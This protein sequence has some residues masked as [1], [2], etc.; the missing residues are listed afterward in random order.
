M[1]RKILCTTLAAL[2]I[3]T[4]GASLIAPVQAA[5]QDD[6]LGRMLT[7]FTTFAQARIKTLDRSQNMARSKMV[8]IKE[9]PSYRGTYHT[10]DHESL[11]CKV[12]K[13]R[14]ETIPFVGVMKFNVHIW[15]AKG[16]T[17]E[18]VKNGSFAPVKIQPNRQIYSF[19]G[20]A[21]K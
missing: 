1:R 10:F 15:Q 7:H 4:L 18:A 12:R 2:I 14:S 17:I 13:S 19:K 21:W 6:E 20:G 8:V 11:T 5:A 3:G 16:E 9:G